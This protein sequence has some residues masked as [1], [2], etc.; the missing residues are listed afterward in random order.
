M[1][2]FISIAAAL[3]TAM[4]AGAMFENI[5]STRIWNDE[6]EMFDAMD[7]GELITDVDGNGVFNI[8]DCFTL[9]SC[10]GTIE[11]PKFKFEEYES[12]KDDTYSFADYD[13]SGKTDQSDAIH[14][15]RYYIVRNKLSRQ[16]TLP[17]A[18]DSVSGQGSVSSDGNSAVSCHYIDI[19][20]GKKF[21]RELMVQADY[22]MAGY[23]VFCDM[24]ESGEINYDF[25]GDGR[26]FYD[27]INYLWVY[28]I[29]SDNCAYMDFTADEAIP[30]PE[31]IYYPC[32]KASTYLRSDML[33][34]TASRIT[35]QTR[36]IFP[37]I[38]MKVFSRAQAFMILEI[39]QSSA[40]KNGSRKTSISPSTALAS[41]GNISHS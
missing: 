26:L 41:T 2:K 8:Y 27:D 1:K 7:S 34:C 19:Y 6:F 37:T 23:P 38:T 28:V 21:S 11:S 29:N 4:T 10:T 16:I 39:T 35:V 40:M 18:Y 5:P 13:G 22:L 3:A 33:L 32:Q 14:L 12:E 9:Y 30:L 25:N 17:S 36:N 20:P 31:E 15:I 24:L